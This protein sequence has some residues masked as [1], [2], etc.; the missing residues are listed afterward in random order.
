LARASDISRILYAHPGPCRR[1]VV[2]RRYVEYPSRTT[3]DGWLRSPLLDN[4]Q[5]LDFNNGHLLLPSVHRF[6][7]TLCI[8]SFRA[9][10]LPDGNDASPLQLPLLKQL[11]LFAVGISESSLHA[12]LASCPVLESLLLLHNS[13]FGRLQIVSSSLRSIGVESGGLCGIR[14]QQLVIED[15]PSLERLLYFGR[16]EMN[17]LV[18]S[19]PRLAILGKLF[20]GFPRLQFG[21]TVFQVRTCMRPHFHRHDRSKLN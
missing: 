5:E 13:G 21:A 20:D 9:C 2:P 18:I 12:L 7:S 3:L 4:L 16:T 17:I 14:L 10:R 8:A 1:F 15:A 19:A 6:S 11:T